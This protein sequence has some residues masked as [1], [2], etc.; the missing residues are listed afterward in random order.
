MNIINPQNLITFIFHLIVV[1]FVSSFIEVEGID[2]AV[3]TVMCLAC[4]FIFLAIKLMTLTN[5]QAQIEY[6]EFQD[7][8]SEIKRLL[9]KIN[10]YESESKSKDS[11]IERLKLENERLISDLSEAQAN[12]LAIEQNST[13]LSEKFA[14]LQESYDLLYKKY[15]STANR[16]G[17][18]ARQEKTTAEP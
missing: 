10:Q 5:E 2:Q 14:N 7:M 8:K 17:G 11:E 9:I 16:V 3:I 1:S 18:L 13:A 4:Y 15:R 6:E 12:T